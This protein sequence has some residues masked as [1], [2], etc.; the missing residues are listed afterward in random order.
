MDNTLSHL[1]EE[2]LLQTAA[3]L[4]NATCALLSAVPRQQLRPDEALKQ[5]HQIFEAHFRYLKARQCPL[6]N[7]GQH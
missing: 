1:N 2:C 4:A 6:Q 7:Q 3:S 5:T